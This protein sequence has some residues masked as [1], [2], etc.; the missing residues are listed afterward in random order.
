VTRL[1]VETAGQGRDLVLLHGWGLH[2]GAWDELVPTLARR[3]RVHAIDLPGH[4]HS[5]AIEVRGFGEAVDLVAERVPEGAHVCGWSLGGLIAQGLATRRGARVDRLALV[6][7]TPC[8]AQRPGWS[9]AMKESTLAEFAAGL[10]ID[11]EATL[12]RF[13]RLNAL[14]GTLGREAIRAFTTRLAQRGPPSPATLE[15]SLGWLREVDLR[16]QVPS[17]ASPTLVVHGTRDQ[18]APVEAGRWLAAAIPGARLM[19]IGD[20]AHLP[21][22]THR[23]AFASALEAHLG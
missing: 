7:A 23:D 15:A 12:A 4:G 22:F 11:R 19:E 13:V 5:A 16:A 10:A 9:A 20:A 17:I 18:L 21:F 14:N 1:H 8:F 3:Y 6:G 2:S